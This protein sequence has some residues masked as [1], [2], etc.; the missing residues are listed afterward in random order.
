[1]EKDNCC[2]CKAKKRFEKVEKDIKEIKEDIKDISLNI[3][4][5]VIGKTIKCQKCSYIWKT[6]SEMG[7]TSCPRCATKVKNESELERNKRIKE[8]KQ[9][10]K[11]KEFLENLKCPVCHQKSTGANPENMC[12]KCWGK[13]VKKTEFR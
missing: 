10:K 6:K 7:Y 11:K 4:K 9:E 3:T 13:A 12:N 1:M 2:E 8:I 5:K